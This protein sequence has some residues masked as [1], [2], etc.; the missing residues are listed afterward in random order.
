MSARQSVLSY[1]TALSFGKRTFPIRGRAMH[2]PTIVKETYAMIPNSR[3]ENRAVVSGGF[4]CFTQLL[5]AVKPQNAEIFCKKSRKQTK[6][7][8]KLYTIT[9]IVTENLFDKNMQICCPL[10]EFVLK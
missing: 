3:R 5:I 2:A 1:Q 8:R 4:L 7:A 10:S 9:K 6:K